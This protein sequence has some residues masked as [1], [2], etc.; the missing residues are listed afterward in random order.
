MHGIYGQVNVES[1]FFVVLCS[2]V[3]LKDGGLWQVS[4][5]VPGCAEARFLGC[6]WGVLHVVLS[7]VD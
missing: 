7:K 1:Y 6:D 3:L 4:N 2:N 5:G